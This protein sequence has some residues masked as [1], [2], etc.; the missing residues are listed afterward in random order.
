[1]KVTEYASVF[2]EIADLLF[3][4]VCMVCGQILSPGD[5][6]STQMK[7]LQICV[8]CLSKFPIRREKDRW[9][10]CLSDPYETDPIPDF[11]VWAMLHYSMPVT[12]LL[13]RMKFQSARYCGTLIG[14]LMGREF[15]KDLPVKFQAMIP[16]PLS[17]K[18]KAARGFNQA[19]VLGEE[20]ASQ[21]Q[22]PL[23]PEVLV[24]TR[25]TGQQSRFHD[26]LQ[27]EGNVAGAFAVE[28]SW[29]IR[30][31]NILLIDDILT[32]GATLHEAA[33]V[34]Y[35]AGAALVVGVVA[36]THRENSK[37]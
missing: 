6:C 22:I 34:L 35:Q 17:E 37:S 1:M 9:F 7:D 24:R 18:R 10:P 5:N 19:E 29:D 14:M 33:R 4:S 31:W 36:A 15:P 23:L 8:K 32:S 2:R 16:I 26:P 21:L 3:P 11:K 12:M 30:G 25:H 27:R 28:E 13:R 20:L